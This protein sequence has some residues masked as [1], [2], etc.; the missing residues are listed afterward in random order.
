MKKLLASSYSG[1]LSFLQPAI[2]QY[3]ADFHLKLASVGIDLSDYVNAYKRIPQQQCSKYIDALVKETCPAISIKACKHLNPALLN[4]F[5]TG[6]LYSSSLRDF[7]QRYI[8]GFAFITNLVDV[9]FVEQDSESYLV[10]TD[11]VDFNQVN[12]NFYSDIFSAL[13]LSLL[14]LTVG[15]NSMVKK[16]CLTWT[17]P[18]DI[19]QDYV[20]FFGDNV[21]FSADET[22]VV[23]DNEQLDV[24][25]IWAN[26]TLAAQADKTVKEFIERSY[27]FDLTSKV[28][29]VI[30]KLLPQGKCSKLI[31]ADICGMSEST[32][33]NKLNVEGTS[34]Q[35]IVDNLRKKLAIRYL[36]D[37]D[38]TLE[39]ISYKLGYYSCSNFSRAFKSWFALT[40]VE[41]K[42]LDKDFSI[43]S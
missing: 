6:L 8:N 33:Q 9:D 14:K 1:S 15:P 11:T 21:E 25:F 36:K 22:M 7:C 42:K 10:I 27:S 41:Y 5:G 16:V 13:T 35:K 38:L 17:P 29:N 32:L 2:E 39:Q 4:S 40:P 28:T 12:S 26:E 31:I 24:E 34:F 43:A 23:F 30:A 20:D 3:T 18:K 19:I 37:K